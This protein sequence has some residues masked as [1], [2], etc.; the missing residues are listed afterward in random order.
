MNGLQNAVTR[1][2]GLAAF[3]W[4]GWAYYT[5]N[6]WHFPAFLTVVAYLSLIT[7]NAE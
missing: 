6:D 7:G 4:A 1:L 2:W 5:G 3:V